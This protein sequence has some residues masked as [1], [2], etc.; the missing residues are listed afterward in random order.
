MIQVLMSV[1][2]IAMHVCVI[3]MH[4]DMFG[5]T[6]VKRI[7]NIIGPIIPLLPHKFGWPCGC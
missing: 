3:T 6:P 1:P 5:F 2:M 7:I 4:M